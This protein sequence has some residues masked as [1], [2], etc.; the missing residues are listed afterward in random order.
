MVRVGRAW[1]SS[2]EIQGKWNRSEQ[3]K[4]GG[5]GLQSRDTKEPPASGHQLGGEEGGGGGQSK[6]DMKEWGRGAGPSSEAS[7]LVEA[8]QVLTSLEE[9]REAQ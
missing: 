3:G 6:V 9:F 1:T 2:L 4:Q 8:G 7:Y 5:L